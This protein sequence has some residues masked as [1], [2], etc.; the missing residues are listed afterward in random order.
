MKIFPFWTIWR[1]NELVWRKHIMS[2]LIGNLGQPLLFLLA[3]G[4]GLGR[5]IKTIEGLSYLQF[6]APGLV[7]SAV[8][9]SAAFETTYGS[10]TRLTIQKTYEAILI[11]PLRVT[12]LVLGEVFWAATKGLIA[13]TIMLATLPLFG[14]WP[15]AWTVALLP[16]LFMSGVFF[17]AFGL[18]MT[19]LATNYDF[20]NYFISLIITPLFLFSG[21]F[22][23]LKTMA[24]NTRLFFEVLPLTPI[25]NLARMFC[26]GQIQGP[27]LLQITGSLLIT[28]ITVWLAIILLQR[29]LI[30]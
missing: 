28:I 11:T 12:D 29:R 26:Y 15:S 27:W 18:I 23:S 22:F 5:D 21:I 25:V 6:I 9:Y 2:S 3:M 19:A 4:Y 14:V 20:F 24:P 16:V 30:Q 10:Y 13:G 1:R 17:A 7:A 8:M